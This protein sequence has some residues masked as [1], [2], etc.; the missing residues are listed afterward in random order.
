M[1]QHR[2]LRGSSKITS[3]RNVLKRFR[4]PWPWVEEDEAGSLND[5][6]HGRKGPPTP[7][8][9]AAFFL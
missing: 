1:S 8:G 5:T 4:R 2:S 3:K 7:L 9:Q 6:V